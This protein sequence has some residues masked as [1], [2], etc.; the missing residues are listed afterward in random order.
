MSISQFF[1]GHCEQCG[2]KFR[3]LSK[4]PWTCPVNERHQPVKIRGP[5]EPGMPVKE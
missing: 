3:V 5:Y 4:D 2:R 1:L